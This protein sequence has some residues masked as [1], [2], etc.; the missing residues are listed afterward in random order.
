MVGPLP[1]SRTLELHHFR[2]S[3]LPSPALDLSSSQGQV[4]PIDMWRN[5][6]HEMRK[7]GSKWEDG[8]G[9]TTKGH[10]RD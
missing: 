7:L 6:G 8:A 9:Q 3:P 4:S 5:Y 10:F 2:T 1:N